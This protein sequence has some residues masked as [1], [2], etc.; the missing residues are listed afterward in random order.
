MSSN[1]PEGIDPA[2]VGVCDTKKRSP[3]RLYISSVPG[4]PPLGAF[5]PSDIRTNGALEVSV[6]PPQAVPEGAAE[7]TLINI[8][9]LKQSIVAAFISFPVAGELVSG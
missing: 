8:F 5:L 4:W 9:V 7:Q 2:G 1:S 3:S 6:V